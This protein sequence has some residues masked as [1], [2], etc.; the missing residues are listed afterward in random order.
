MDERDTVNSE[1]A[2]D[3]PISLIGLDWGSTHLRAFAMDSE[4]KIIDRVHSPHGAMTL[5]GP[6]AFDRALCN[7]VG[8]WHAS[9]PQSTLIASGMVGSVNGWSEARYVAVGATAQ[10]VA[11]SLIAV[12]TSL[13]VL[14]HIVPG[15]KSDAPDVMRGEET[16]IIGSGVTDGVIVL[17][18]THSKW[19]RVSDA[20]LF[21]F[22][23]FFTGELNALIRQHSA[24]GKAFDGAADLGDWS[25]IARGVARARANGG[26]GRWL[27]ELFA[28]RAS[29]VTQHRSAAQSSTEF[30][31]WLIASEYIAALAAYPTTKRIHL[32]ASEKLAA[33]YIAIAAAFDVECVV[34]DGEQCAARGLWDISRYV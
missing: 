24:V 1:L 26:H 13:G 29:V 23:T 32:I 16:Q 20:A 8:D 33:W 21:G 15:V 18:G 25:S 27:A 31:A 4:G 28:F 34:L 7:A 14:M 10:T 30:G 17:P 22:T 5:S 6:A 11:R 9:A 19:A 12:D 3:A 2:V